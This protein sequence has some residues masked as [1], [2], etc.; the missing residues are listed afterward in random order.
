MRRPSGVCVRPIARETFVSRGDGVRGSAVASS[1]VVDIHD[2]RVRMVDEE[3][4]AFANDGAQEWN[5]F[6]DIVWRGEEM[7]MSNELGAIWVASG[8]A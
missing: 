7:K 2:R 1:G 6:R 8:R 5:C 4:V 3:A